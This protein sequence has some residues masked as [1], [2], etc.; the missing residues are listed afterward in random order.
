M[1]TVKKGAYNPGTTQNFTST[2]SVAVSNAVG[3]ATAIIRVAVNQDTWVLVGAGLTT[4][5]F[6]VTSN[7]ANNN[8]FLIPA[9]GVEFFVTTP[10]ASI[11]AFAANSTGGPVSITE[12]A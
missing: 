7:I 2:T 6:T 3:S 9:G 8:A 12:L 10:G 11:V 5:S 1:L 4:S